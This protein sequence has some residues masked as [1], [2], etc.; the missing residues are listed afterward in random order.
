M[1]M[2]QGRNRS[3]PVAQMLSQNHSMDWIHF[4]LSQWLQN[5]NINISFEIVMDESAALI[6]AT[7]AAFTQCGSTVNYLEACMNAILHKSERPNCFI[8]TDRSHFVKSIHRNVR[9]GFKKTVNL[10]RGVLGYLISCEDYE[11]SEKIIRAL[12]TIILNEFNSPTVLSC[13]ADLR[14]LVLTHE[15]DS[16]FKTIEEKDDFRNDRSE[17]EN[18]GAKFFKKSLNYQWVKNIL[19]S[20]QISTKICDENMYYAPEYKKYLTRI[21]VRLPLWSNIMLG[22]FESTNT[23]ATSSAVENAFKEIKSLL[24]LNVKRRLDT[25]VQHHLKSLSGFLKIALADEAT[26][27]LKSRKRRYASTEIRPSFDRKSLPKRAKRSLSCED[28]DSFNEI[29]LDSSNF[30]DFEI[31]NETKIPYENWKNKIKEERTPKIRNR[32]CQQSILSKHDP[33][34]LHNFIRMLSNGKETRKLTTVN[35]CSFDSIYAVFGVAC[36]TTI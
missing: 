11:E 22:T 1:I 34:Y 28:C 14:A 33:E 18:I 7:V 24:K 12:F 10:I 26:V 23:T 9:K 21:F 29:S 30:S 32:R 35:T 36:L 2:C 25:F 31:D 4:W 13:A 15:I 16:L 8:R 17:D 19:K 20:V 5:N 6:G 27:P 3:F